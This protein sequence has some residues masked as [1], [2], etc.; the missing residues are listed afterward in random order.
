[1]QMDS[2][3]K[4]EMNVYKVNVTNIDYNQFDSVIIAATTQDE[5][6][7]IAV[8]TTYGPY[9][10]PMFERNQYPLIVSPV[11][12]TTPGIIHMSLLQG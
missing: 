8:K 1:M 10:E 4:D 3:R 12:M 5:A 7:S 11:D 9:E 2:E 6:L